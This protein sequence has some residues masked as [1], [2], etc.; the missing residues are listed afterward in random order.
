MS[1]FKVSALMFDLD[2]TLLNTAPQIAEAANAMLA[3]MGLSML[4]AN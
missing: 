2:G 4:Y 3:D 1:Q